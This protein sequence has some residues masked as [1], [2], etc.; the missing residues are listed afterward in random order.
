MDPSSPPSDAEHELSELRARAY[1]PHPDIQTDPVALARLTELE[2]A[3]IASPPDG[4]HTEIGAPAAAADGA[5]AADSAWT[6]SRGDPPDSA[7]GIPPLTESSGSSPRLLWHR[8]TATRARRSSAVA[9]AVVAI[10]TLAYTVASLVGPHPDAR[11]HSIADEPDGVVL[12]LIDFLGIDA[13]PSTIRGYETYRGVQPWFLV[14]AQGFHCFMII[15]RVG[16]GVDGANCVPPEVDLFAD[17]GPPRV[18]DDFSEVPDGSIIRF[19]YRGDSVDV[20]IYP[21]SQ[22]D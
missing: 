3:R 17:I 18:G 6:A 10:V 19:H 14:N 2:A 16:G 20:F 8:L 21:S 5:P 4:A 1:G 22:A 12:S 11:L 7:A 9:G 15:Q 13:D